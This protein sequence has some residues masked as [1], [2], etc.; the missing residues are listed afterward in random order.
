MTPMILAAISTF[1]P[2]GLARTSSQTRHLTSVAAL[3]KIICSFLHWRHLTFTNFDLGV[4]N[5]SSPLNFKFLG[6]E[7]PCF[8]V[9]FLALQT[10]QSY[11]NTLG[12]L[13]Y[14]GFWPGISS[15]SPQYFTK[16]PLP[17]LKF[18][19]LTFLYY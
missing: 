8:C 11:I 3:L 15:I 1:P 2:V 6:P 17:C 18:T 13:D 19:S 4:I 7:C 14:L 16:P 9:F 12:L 10:L 5:I